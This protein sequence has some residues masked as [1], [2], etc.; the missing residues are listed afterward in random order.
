MYIKILSL[1]ISIFFIIEIS[2]QEM[3]FEEYNPKSTLVVEGEEITKSKFPF[4]D[5]HSH[6]RN[7]DAKV[8][9]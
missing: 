5:V 4:I 1:L 7:M 9:W 3:G 2:A 6:Q 8:L